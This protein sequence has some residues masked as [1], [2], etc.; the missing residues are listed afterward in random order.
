[1]SPH[2]CAIDLASDR[3]A[4][5]IVKAIVAIPHGLNLSTIAEG[6]ETQA[7]LQ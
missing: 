7:Q 3:I 2:L 6:I 4:C 1:M 5:G